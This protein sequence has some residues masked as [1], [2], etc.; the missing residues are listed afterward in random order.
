MSPVSHGL[1]SPSISVV[2]KIDLV[3]KQWI[4]FFAHSDWLLR[5]PSAIH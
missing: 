5:I 3:L 2:H 4:V 1:T